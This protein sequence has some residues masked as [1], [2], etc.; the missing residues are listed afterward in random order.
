[1][2]YGL[3]DKTPYSSSAY[4]ETQLSGMRDLTADE[5]TAYDAMKAE[6]RDRGIP[7]EQD[8]EGY[9]TDRKTGKTRVR[10]DA[11]SLS[12]AERKWAESNSTE[13]IDKIRNRG[14]NMDRQALNLRIMYE[15]AK[16][17]AADARSIDDIKKM[18]WQ[19]RR[20]RDIA[21]AREVAREYSE[22]LG[23]PV[24][25]KD[26]YVPTTVPMLSEKST[27][28]EFRERPRTQRVAPDLIVSGPGGLSHRKLSRA[29]AMAMEVNE[30][31]KE[32]GYA[33]PTMLLRAEYLAKRFGL[34]AVT[35]TGDL[36]D[37]RGNATGRTKTGR[38]M[39]YRARTPGERAQAV[40]F[41]RVADDTVRTMAEHTV[42]Q[43]GMPWEAAVDMAR[44]SYA[45]GMA[46]LRLSGESW[47]DYD[48]D[49]RARES[50]YRRRRT[51]SLR[52]ALALSP[53]AK[54][55]GLYDPVLERSVRWRTR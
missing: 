4:Q 21:T 50:A 47:F 6:A 28:T 19:V 18:A 20:N 10:W 43:T 42:E 36:Y 9:V 48:N 13:S 16:T 30:A 26:A 55:L 17:G 2:A 46:D 29:E 52:E 7:V 53:M 25:W 23:K 32:S 15:Y 41:D 5:Q 33:D 31:I 40:S 12:E 34:E 38:T 51:A 8:E 22:A 44:R 54:A 11:L 39:Q 27:V 45:A 49:R 24:D 35:R 3:F 37:G 14:A 1:M